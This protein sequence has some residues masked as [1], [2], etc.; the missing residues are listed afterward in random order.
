MCRNLRD[1][2]TQFHDVVVFFFCFFQREATR[3]GM[4]GFDQNEN[5]IAAQLCTVQI[6]KERLLC[7][8]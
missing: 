6:K 5:A 8:H 7:C 4:V 3:Y 2:T 1:F